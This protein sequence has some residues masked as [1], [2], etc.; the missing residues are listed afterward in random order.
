MRQHET[1]ENDCAMR[2][3]ATDNPSWRPEAGSHDARYLRGISSNRTK[4]LLQLL[5]Q[6]FAVRKNVHLGRRVHIGLG[7][8]LWAPQRLTIGDDVYIGKSCTIQC[9]G[10]IGNGVLIGNRVGLVG[11]LDHDFRAVG[12]TVRLSP[13]IGDS[14]YKAGGRALRITVGDDVWIGY[15]A[16]VLT[17]VALGRGAIVSAGAVVV[18]DVASYAIVAGNPAKTIGKRFTTEEIVDHERLLGIDGKA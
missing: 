5:Y 8:I 13:W 1:V 4:H 9:D 16:I 14:N 10:Q 12:V 18:D 3:D 7:S 17:G 2:H 15:G 6:R 11:R